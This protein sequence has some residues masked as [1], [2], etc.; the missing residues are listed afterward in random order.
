MIEELKNIQNPSFR[1]RV[2][3]I[4]IIKILQS[5]LRLGYGL[6]NELHKEFRKPKYLLKVKVFHKDDI[7]SADLIEMPKEDGYHYVLTIIDLYTRYAWTIPM[8]TKTGLE[9]KKAFQ[10]IGHYPKKLW[11]DHGKEFYNK[12][13]KSL[14][15]EIYSTHND[16]KAVVIERF[17]RTLKKMMYKKFTEQKN[18]KWLDI[19]PLVTK[20]YNSKI[21]SSINHS[22]IDAYNNPEKIHEI[23][24]EINYENEN[25]PR[26]SSKPKFKINQHVRIFKWQS[27]FEKGYIAKWSSEVFKIREINNTSPITYEIEDLNGEDIIGTFYQNELQAT[28]Y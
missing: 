24:N 26:I 1:E 8:K 5:K 2:E 15:F 25:N 22:P 6:A 11:V 28:D 12:H 23:Q 21:H 3:R 18:Q 4:M 20:E 9:T 17:N 19:L 14:P 7:W 10:S 16:G 27:K 13:V